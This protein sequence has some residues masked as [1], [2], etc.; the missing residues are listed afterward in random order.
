MLNECP[1][2]F[3]DFV[4]KPSVRNRPTSDTVYKGTV[5]IPYV[6]GISEK[7]GRIGKRFSLRTNFKIKNTLR[8]TLM[9]TGPVRDARQTKQC[10][11]SIPCDCGRRYISE[12]SRP[13]EVRIKEH[14]Y[15]LTQGCLEK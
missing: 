10:V 11:Y 5:V 3:V 7:F 1:K 14:K 15:D 8:G 12:T 2:E 6:K 4:T 13:L 9:K